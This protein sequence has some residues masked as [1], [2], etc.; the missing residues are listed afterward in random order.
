MGRPIIYKKSL[1]GFS[2]YHADADHMNRLFSLKTLVI[3]HLVFP[4]LLVHC[5]GT[6]ETVNNEQDLDEIIRLAREE[7][8]PVSDKIIEYYPGMNDTMRQKAIDK[9]AELDEPEA[10][11]GLG[12]LLLHKEIQHTDGQKNLIVGYLISRKTEASAKIVKQALDEQRI[13]PTK[14][15]IVFFGEVPYTPAAPDILTGMEQGH[16]VESSI[17]ALSRMKMKEYDDRILDIAGDKSHP[18]HLTAIRSLPDISDQ[19]A[20]GQVYHDVLQESID[21]PS[22]KGDAEVVIQIIGQREYESNTWEAL[23]DYYQNSERGTT[24]AQAL[25]SMAQIKKTKNAFVENEVILPLSYIQAVMG[26]YLDDSPTSAP[27]EKKSKPVKKP[28]ERKPKKVQRIRMVKPRYSNSYR[29]KVKSLLERQFPH[30][31][32]SMI[33]RK[34][35][36]ALIAYSKDENSTYT[37]FLIRA[38]RTGFG[39]DEENARRMLAIGLYQYGAMGRIVRAVVREY[40]SDNMRHYMLHRMFRIK[41]KEAESLVNMVLRNKL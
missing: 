11:N 6:P 13:N 3:L 32:G 36:H 21:D 28:P 20:A 22:R 37:A 16:F 8:T 2:L 38:Y 17:K 41:R 15:I 27:P 29:E 19:E 14:R 23:G 4:L 35:H 24:K 1:S 34:I 39:T 33:D 40:D 31:D 5:A 25:K 12:K 10:T 26:Y 30:G 7:G 18:Y 9:I